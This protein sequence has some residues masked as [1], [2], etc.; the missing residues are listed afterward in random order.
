MTLLIAELPSAGSLGKLQRKRSSG[1]PKNVSQRTGT[2]F[3]W[4]R[5]AGGGCSAREKIESDSGI[6][7]LYGVCHDAGSQTLAEVRKDS[8]ER[9]EKGDHNHHAPALI[10]VSGAKNQR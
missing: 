4:R 1:F 5:N 9:A 7:V 8:E 2:M 6:C 10:T 3:F